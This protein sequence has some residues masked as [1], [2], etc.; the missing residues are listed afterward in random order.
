MMS[1]RGEQVEG[2]LRGGVFQRDRRDAEMDSA[3]PCGNLWLPAVLKNKAGA[4]RCAMQT[5]ATFVFVRES[6][7]EKGKGE[8]QGH[9]SGGRRKGLS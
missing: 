3:G 8:K 9:E 4:A 7:K 6:C 2:K 1:L 5:N